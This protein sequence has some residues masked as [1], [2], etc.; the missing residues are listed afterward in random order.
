[1][2]NM[3][4]VRHGM[5]AD[6]GT[7]R[8]VGSVLSGVQLS[9]DSHLPVSVTQCRNRVDNPPGKLHGRNHE[10]RHRGPQTQN[11]HGQPPGPTP[12]ETPRHGPHARPCGPPVSA[13]AASPQE[14]HTQP[15]GP[16]QNPSAEPSKS[17]HGSLLPTGQPNPNPR[18]RNALK[19]RLTWLKHR[20]IIRM[21]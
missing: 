16:R 8:A 7:L 4:R 15:P 12:R 10:R 9:N 3:S 5:R 21:K 17:T 6:T 14:R 19:Y 2:D 11:G 1:M 18:P 13:C 20:P